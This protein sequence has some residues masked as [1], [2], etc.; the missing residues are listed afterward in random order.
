MTSSPYLF[1]AGGDNLTGTQMLIWFAVCFLGSIW[2]LMRFARRDRPDSP[3]R[4]RAQM[5]DDLAAEIRR[6]ERL[7]IRHELEQRRRRDQ[8]N[9]PD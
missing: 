1:A 3:T 5:Q 2:I 9:D 4:I 7:R 8:G 6:D